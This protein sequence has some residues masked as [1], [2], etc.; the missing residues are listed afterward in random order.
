MKNL[1]F[2]LIA[3]FGFSALTQAQTRS[4]DMATGKPL[5][6]VTL[7]NKKPVDRK[8]VFKDKK[9]KKEKKIKK[10]RRHMLK[11]RHDNGLHLGQYKNKHAR[12]AKK[13]KVKV[14]K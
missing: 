13:A 11:Q 10:G 6:E 12:G 5:P 1:L 8:V 14:I 3:V 7:E 2:T 9:V 4:L